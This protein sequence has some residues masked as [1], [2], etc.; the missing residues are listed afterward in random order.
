MV[1][2]F[3]PLAHV[4]AVPFSTLISPFLISIAAFISVAVA[5]MVFVA[6]V[7]LAVYV[8]S[9]ALNDGLSV[10]APIVNADNELSGVTPPQ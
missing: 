7:V 5:L 2:V 6:L 9:P 1:T 4:I 3:A 10:S 8:I